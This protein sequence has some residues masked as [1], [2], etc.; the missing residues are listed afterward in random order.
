MLADP[1]PDRG[2]ALILA[3]VLTGLSGFAKAA[4]DDTPDME[5]LEYLGSW[6]GEEEDWVWI[7][8]AAESETEDDRDDP[9][10]QGD[11]VAELEDES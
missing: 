1:R 8:A 6:E 10:P 5:F 7:A 3:L 2:L 11:K 9:A 4:E